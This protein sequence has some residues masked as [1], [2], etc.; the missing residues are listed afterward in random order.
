MIASLNVHST[1]RSDT[2]T[3]TD[4]LAP[5]TAGVA[6]PLAVDDLI[7]TSAVVAL[8]AGLVDRIVSPFSNGGRRI[9]AASLFKHRER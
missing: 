7:E 3:A 4:S 9:A 1:P 6:L 8:I 2:I 5:L